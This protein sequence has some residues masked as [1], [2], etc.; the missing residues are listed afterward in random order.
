LKNEKLEFS[1]V[2][3]P[4]EKLKSN[5]NERKQKNLNGFSVLYKVD[6]VVSKSKKR[7][8]LFY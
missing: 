3:K 1:Y 8:V 4:K 6:V 7:N 2:E 5:F